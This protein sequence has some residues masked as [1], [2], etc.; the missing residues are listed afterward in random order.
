MTI[1]VAF[2]QPGVGTWIG[3]DRRT[4]M[5]GQVA[6]FNPKWAVSPCGRKAIAYAGPTRG[7]HLANEFQARLFGARDP[8]DVAARLRQLITEDG[9]TAHTDA[10]DPQ[11]YNGAAIYAEDHGVWFIT[12]DFCVIAIPPGRLWADGS[13]REYA[14]G[15]AHAMSM[16]SGVDGSAL[17]RTAVEAACANDSGCG[18]EPFI[19]LLRDTR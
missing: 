10:G 17:V 1:N 2:H 5:G 8:Y 12:C 14:F 18:G 6:D 9:W 3:S 19:D 7:N 11:H 13:G 4:T 16:F 15:A